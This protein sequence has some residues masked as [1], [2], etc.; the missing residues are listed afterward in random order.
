MNSNILNSFFK[1]N[2]DLEEEIFRF[3][4]VRPE[5]VRAA[6]AF[7][8][9]TRELETLLG[10]EGYCRFEERLNQYRAMESEAYYLFGLGLRQDLLWALGGVSPP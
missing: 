3:C 5:Y 9:V 1:D 10:Y 6:E 4:S 2:P 8:Q 7:A